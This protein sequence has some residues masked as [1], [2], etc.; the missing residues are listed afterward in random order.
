MSLIKLILAIAFVTVQ[1]RS[2]N[3]QDKMDKLNQLSNYNNIAAIVSTIIKENI[4]VDV[5]KVFNSQNSAII[6]KNIWAEKLT[7][8]NLLVEDNK[9]IDT[10]LRI[11]FINNWDKFSVSNLDGFKQPEIVEAISL[12]YVSVLFDKYS[13]NDIKKILDEEQPDP[14]VNAE[15]FKESSHRVNLEF[16]MAAQ[17]MNKTN[18]I[19]DENT[20]NISESFNTKVQFNKLKN[21]MGY[22]E[23]PVAKIE[24]AINALIEKNNDPIFNNNK[25]TDASARIINLVN[26]VNEINN[27]NGKN[28]AS[29]DLIRK[30]IRDL[31]QR[32]ND[33]TKDDHYNTYVQWNENL[34]NELS[35]L[36]PGDDEIH[37]EKDLNKIH[38]INTNKIS[39]DIKVIKKEDSSIESVLKNPN[40]DIIGPNKN[41]LIED[42][43]N[44]EEDKYVIP[45]Q[46][47]DNISEITTLPQKTDAEFIDSEKDI[48][49]EED[50][51]T[52]YNKATN[53]NDDNRNET[54]IQTNLSNESTFSNA[55]DTDKIVDDIKNLPDI[56]TIKIDDATIV[57]QPVHKQD[58]LQITS[59]EDLG[60]DIKS[61]LPET[62]K[63]KDKN[64]VFQIIGEVGAQNIEELENSTDLMNVAFKKNILIPLD[65]DSNTVVELTVV[66]VQTPESGCMNDNHFVKIY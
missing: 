18:E 45:K 29:N 16:I 19:I 28:A 50:I 7:E 58:E 23:N 40:Q 56:N 26:N 53:I 62:L 30:I 31:R 8:L 24:L 57:E 43:I 41:N 46:I 1:I 10:R 42:Q 4:F 47:K 37:A 35:K 11:A 27:K 36:L 3:F 51:I 12:V 64:L 38:E 59:T 13:I 32:R 66:Y 48:K 52:S 6:N 5:E 49:R 44:N 63:Q 55:V 39:D 21:L 54:D 14:F 25:G 15:V 61:L 22:V 65:G 33:K 60:I 2:L 20:N 34:E 9:N 17:S